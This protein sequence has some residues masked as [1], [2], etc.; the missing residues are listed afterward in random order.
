MDKYTCIYTYIYM[1]TCICMYIY[2]H[3]YIYMCIYACSSQPPHST[4]HSTVLSS[5]DVCCVYDVCM[6]VSAK[7]CINIV[8]CILWCMLWHVECMISCMLSV[9]CVHVRGV[10]LMCCVYQVM[11]V[12]CVL[13]LHTCDCVF[14]VACDIC[15]VYPVC[16]YASVEERT[17]HI[18]VSI[19]NCVCIVRTH[20]CL[21]VFIIFIFCMLCGNTYVRVCSLSS[22]YGC[23]LRV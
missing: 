2:T 4:A 19:S 21:C 3:T 12:L 11:Y 5:C 20:V 14:C 17:Y 16:L 22:P 18:H 9:W 7:W 10:Y 8:V 1:Y 23:V 6:Y 13:C 15:W